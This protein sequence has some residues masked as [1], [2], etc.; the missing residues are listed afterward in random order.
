M[1]RWV[2]DL[3]K[4]RRARKAACAV[5]LPMVARS[6][7]RLGTIPDD[8]WSAPYMVGF[9]VMLI[10]IIAK[11]EIGKIEGQPLCLVQA[12][13]WGDITGIRSD[14]IGEDV[15]LLSAARNRDFENGCHN[16]MGLASLLIGS[17]ILGWQHQQSD[18][19]MHAGTPWPDRDDLSSLWERLFDAHIAVHIR[20]I[21]TGFDKA[22]LE[23][24]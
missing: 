15:L 12:K 22:P 8:A 6:R 16:A 5:I 23:F 13:A 3:S 18:L 1:L 10:T 20:G 21:E 11:T 19:G 9:M 24:L 4:V 2:L 17:S 7:H 14:L